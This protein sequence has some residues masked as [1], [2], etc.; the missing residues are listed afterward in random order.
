LPLRLNTFFQ[1]LAFSLL[2][3]AVGGALSGLGFLGNIGSGGGGILQSLGN[4]LG[5]SS[6]LFTIITAVGASAFLGQIFTVLCFGDSMSDDE[7][8][9]KGVCRMIIEA[10]KE[11]LQ[12]IEKNDSEGILLQFIC[13]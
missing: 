11:F 8:Y 2:D 7:F 4:G 10:A 5:G 1:G 6:T 13:C 9:S 12:Y 3:T